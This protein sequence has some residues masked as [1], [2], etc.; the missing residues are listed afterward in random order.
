MEA[1]IEA[2]AKQRR[3]KAAEDGDGDG[4]GEEVVVLKGAG[5]A[6]ERCLQVGMKLMGEADL[7]VRLRTGSVGAVDDLVVDEEVGGGDGVEDAGGEGEEEV[8]EVPEA[9]MR[10]VSFV[11]VVVGLR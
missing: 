3:N 2:A 10:Q 4:G 11:E 6:V 8:E 5:R 1:Q 9:R 7:R